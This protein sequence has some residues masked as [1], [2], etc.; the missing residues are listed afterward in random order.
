MKHEDRLPVLERLRELEG[1]ALYITEAL[2]F[3]Q[4]SEPVKRAMLERALDEQALRQIRELSWSLRDELH[5][6]TTQL[7]LSQSASINAA[8]SRPA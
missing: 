8:V 5:L 4:R 3:D 2:H 6:V 1:W 7:E